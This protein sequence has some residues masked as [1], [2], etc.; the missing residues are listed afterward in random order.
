MDWTYRSRNAT[1]P[2]SIY[3][4]V[5]EPWMGD[6]RMKRGDSWT[7]QS[8]RSRRNFMKIGAL[9]ASSMLAAPAVAKAG[10]ICV[11]FLGCI[12]TGRGGGGGGPR[13]FLK[14]T[15]IRT[16]D[17]F[18]KVENLAAGDLLPTMFHGPC[19]IQWIGRYRYKK[20][21]PASP[22]V[23]D[24]LPVRISRSAL[25]DNVP[26][27]DLFITGSHS[28]FI[29]DVL[30]PVRNLVNGTTI[31]YYPARELDELEYFHIKLEHHDVISAEGTPCDTLLDVDE[32]AVNFVD[33]LREFGAPSRGNAPCAPWVG[34]G[35][36]VE[37]KSR[38]RSALSPWIDR[39]EKLDMIR[40]K[41]EEGEF[42]L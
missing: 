12:R 2:V 23:E 8:A 16:A 13:C 34:F 35:V 3:G 21:D 1:E 40:D 30:V 39:R 14:G 18:M 15:T 11:P 6:L 24:V 32:N 42:V 19:P 29:D 17:G 37:L 22:W 28:L 41:L 5:P 33:Y 20:S 26:D 10:E 36:R 31:S 9:A 7:T 25:G 38:L 4:V 27:A